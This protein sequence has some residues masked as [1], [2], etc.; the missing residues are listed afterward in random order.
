MNEEIWKPIKG[1]ENLYEVS[2]LGRVRSLTRYKK[3]LK[4]IPNKFGYGFV[5]LYK[6]KKAIRKAVHRIVAE[7]FIP[8]LENKREVNHISGVKTDNRVCNLE[9]NTSQE[10]RLHAI[11][12]NLWKHVVKKVKQYDLQGN[13][14]KEWDSMKSAYLSTGISISCISGCCNGDRKTSCGYIW[15]YAEGGNNEC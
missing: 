10:N 11:K 9:W 3:I 5:T 6:N 1:F 8:N 2:D 15:R 12:N 7:T 13:F 14:I 4:P